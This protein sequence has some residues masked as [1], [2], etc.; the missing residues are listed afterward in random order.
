MWIAND[1]TD[2][3]LTANSV[4][5]TLWG[6]LGSAGGLLVPVLLPKLGKRGFTTFTT[7]TNFLACTVWGWAPRAWAMFG[8][9]WSVHKRS[10]LDQSSAGIS[11]INPSRGEAKLSPSRIDQVPAWG[12]LLTDCGVITA[13]I[14]LV[15]T[16]TRHSAS[17]QKRQR[18]PSTL[19]WD[20]ASSLDTSRTSEQ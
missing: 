19:D 5:L 9:I 12:R 8:G 7:F 18:P 1:V 20:A 6:I 16:Q 17:R 15:S 2:M 14:S 4:Y 3:G 11:W 10:F 13:C